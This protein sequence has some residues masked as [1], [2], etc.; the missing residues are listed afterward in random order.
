[1]IAAESGWSFAR[2]RSRCA[3]NMDGGA[4]IGGKSI[5]ASRVA[6]RSSAATARNAPFLLVMRNAP[7]PLV[8]LSE[9]ERAAKDLLD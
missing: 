2:N 3:L 7:S 4:V 8:I 1:M 5:A 9:P 6:P